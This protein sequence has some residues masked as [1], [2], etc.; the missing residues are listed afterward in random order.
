MIVSLQKR[1][2]LI[3]CWNRYPVA[4]GSTQD[5]FLCCLDTDD[6]NLVAHALTKKASMSAQAAINGQKHAMT[7]PAEV[8]ANVGKQDLDGSQSAADC[9]KKTRHEY[10]GQSEALPK[11]R[12]RGD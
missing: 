12:Q 3:P 11:R 10:Q 9:A 8:E 6:T 4:V 2:T 1:L 5:L 7:L